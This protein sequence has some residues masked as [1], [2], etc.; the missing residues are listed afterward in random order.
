MNNFADLTQR[1]TRAKRAQL[2]I[3]I[4]RELAEHVEALGKE[5]RMTKSAV[6]AAMVEHDQEK[7]HEALMA[8]GYLAMNERR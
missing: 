6:I 8:E 5:Y 4:P 1:R 2:T 7:R 3:T